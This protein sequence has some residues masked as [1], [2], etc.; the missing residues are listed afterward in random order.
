MFIDRFQDCFTFMI[1][2]Q[3]TET[4]KNLVIYLKIKLIS[5]FQNFSTSIVFI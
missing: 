2:N 4:I 3:I 1:L 5:F